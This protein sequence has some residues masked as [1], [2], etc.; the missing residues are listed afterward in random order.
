ME[1]INRTQHKKNAY[2]EG[3]GKIDCGDT[4]G[5]RMGRKGSKYIYK[6]TKRQNRLE[7]RC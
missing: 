6:N 3:C 7:W 5:F 1:S 2:T 4:T